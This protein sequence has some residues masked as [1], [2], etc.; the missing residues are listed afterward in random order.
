MPPRFVEFVNCP[1]SAFSFR[2][3]LTWANGIQAQSIMNTENPYL[4]HRSSYKKYPVR[5][6][7]YI[8]LS[9]GVFS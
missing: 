7:P 5:Q 6:N 3:G 8:K 2:Y 1:I 4:L 9:V